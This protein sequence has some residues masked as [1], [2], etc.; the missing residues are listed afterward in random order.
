[1]KKL[2]NKAQHMALIKALARSRAKAEDGMVTA[3]YALGTVATTSI[4]GILIWL[5]QQEWL[6]EAIAS[7]FKLIVSSVA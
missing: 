2:M 6:K 4:A 7:I 1:M 5:S 3:E